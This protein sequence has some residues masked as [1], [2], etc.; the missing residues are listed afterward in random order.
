M[1]EVRSDLLGS[2]VSP[3]GLSNE[4][5]AVMVMDFLLLLMDSRGSTHRRWCRS[6]LS[7]EA[8][9]RGSQRGNKREGRSCVDVR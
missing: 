2:K 9:R 5:L 1:E 4:I 8:R 6:S 3:L 7:V